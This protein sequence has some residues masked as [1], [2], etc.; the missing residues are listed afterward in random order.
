MLAWCKPL[1]HVPIV[2]DHVLQ[3]VENV[4]TQHTPLLM[5]TLEAAAKSRL[6]DS[7]YPTVDKTLIPAQ[8]AKVQPPKLIIVFIVGGTTYEEARVVSEL[9]AQSERHEGW[10]SGTKFVLGGTSVQNSTTFMHDLTEMS[11]NERMYST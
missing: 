1:Q 8:P 2:A 5:Q 11:N 7:E 3:G 9:N 10:A 6:K 4:Y